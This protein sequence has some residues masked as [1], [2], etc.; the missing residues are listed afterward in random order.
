VLVLVRSIIRVKAGFDISNLNAL[1]HVGHSF[2]PAL[3]IAAHGDDFIPP[4]HARKLHEAYQGEKDLYMVSGDHN[5]MRPEVCRK[6]AILFLCRAF[7]CERLDQLLEMHAS[8]LYDIFA[9]PP[10]RTPG[11]DAGCGGKEGAAICQQLQVLPAL[12]M[13]MLVR[14]RCCRR[15][16]VARA[17]MKLL[18]GQSEAGFF[19]RLEPSGAAEAQGLGRFLVLAAS[20]TALMASRISDGELETIA[21]GPGLAL[22]EMQH[23]QVSMDREGNL[24]LQLGDDSPLEFACG[25][26]FREE[27]T[28]WLMLLHGQTSFGALYVDDSEATLRESLGDAMLQERHLGGGALA[29]SDPAPLPR[30]DSGELG[31]AP[32]LI[33]PSPQPVSRGGAVAEGA[34]DSF[35]LLELCEEA[36]DSHPDV[37]ND[38]AQHPE[39]LIGWRLR[40]HTV[41]EGVVVG[42]RRRWGRSTQHLIA[43]IENGQAGAFLDTRRIKPR[44][45]VLCRKESQA[46]KRRGLAFDLL[47]KEF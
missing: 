46:C 1:E 30:G 20:T 27:V 21:V 15:P 22:R 4:H 18:E 40:V 31:A 12:R 17:D 41:G 34:E 3:F 2:Q 33:A 14:Q 38:C 5:S 10:Q 13:M 45:V 23:L 32:A 43:G 11:Q 35:G 44:A 29:T 47:R 37:L 26:S 42:I 7:H 6:K 16:F 36:G 39:A 24:R 25:S 8:G 9:G 19:V 28:L